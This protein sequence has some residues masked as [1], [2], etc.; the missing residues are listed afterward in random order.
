MSGDRNDQARRAPRRLA[1]RDTA[2]RTASVPSAHLLQLLG[3][4]RSGIV[5]YVQ[6]L[7]AQGLPLDAVLHSVHAL[8][9]AAEGAEGWPDELGVMQDQVVRWSVEAYHDGAGRPGPARLS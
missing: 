2:R 5:A 3:E 6:Q 7:R 4:L 8:V 1:L 9:E